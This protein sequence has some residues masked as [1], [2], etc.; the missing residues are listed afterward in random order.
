[1]LAIFSRM[2]RKLTVR[3]AKIKQ[4][5]QKQKSNE[6]RNGGTQLFYEK[7]MGGNFVQCQ[8]WDALFP[9]VHLAYIPSASAGYTAICETILN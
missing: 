1:M 7:Y 8:N 2:K 6:T 4:T 9:T 5:K 3:Q